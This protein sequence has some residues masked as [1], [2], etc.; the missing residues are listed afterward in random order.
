MAPRTPVE[1]LLAGIWA[2]GAGRR[3]GRG[4]TTTSSS[5]AATRCWPRRWCRACA[6]AFG[7]E[8]P[9]RAL[10]EAPT[11]AAL[12]AAGRGGAAPAGAAGA[13]ARAASPRDG[14]AAALL[15]PA[16]ALVPRP[17]RAGQRRLQHARWPCGCEGALDAA[18]LARS[19]RRARAP[20]RGAA[21][22]ASR[23][24]GRP[25]GAGDRSRGRACRCRWSTCRALP[26]AERQAEARA[27]GRRRRRA[28]RSTWRAGPLLR[29]LLLRLAERRPR[30]AADPAPHRL[31][32]AGR[33][34][35]WS[36]SWR[37][38]TR[39]FAAGRPSPLPE[40]PV[41]YA[42]FARL[43]ARL[44]ARARCWR[45]SSPTGGSSSPERRRCWSCP[46]TGRARRCRAPAAR[47]C[48][49]RLAAGA[50]AA[51]CGRSAGA[52]ARRCS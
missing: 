45:R 15:R 51:R 41:Q 30:A 33:W 38:S 29:G 42:D 7:V 28:G 44:A 1:E 24:G 22:H 11:V 21:H 32:T 37:R 25:A 27:P 13:A 19:P 5:W 6:T 9:L 31:A 48:S 12:A 20:P 36:A 16:A 46:P 49:V 35:C 50:G 43:A 52:R 8:L 2:R 4:R 47:R 39:R 17:A 26:E 34:A 18:A 10:F 40:L 14:R 3:A 23:A